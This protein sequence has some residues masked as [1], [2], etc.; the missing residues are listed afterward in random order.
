MSRINDAERT[1]GI[2]ATGVHGGSNKTQL[3]D[4]CLVQNKLTGD[5]MFKGPFAE[6][7][8][9]TSV[10]SPVAFPFW[11]PMFISPLNGKVYR[12]WYI[13]VDYVDGGPDFNQAHGRWSNSPPPPHD[14]DDQLTDTDTWTTSAGVGAEP[15]GDKKEKNKKA[16]AS[17][18]A[19]K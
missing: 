9:L 14:A 11:F 5:Y 8:P 1:W 18:S 15:E 16:V 2:P 12:N 6:G 13:R 4:C 3:V 17:A 7:L 19:K 10:K